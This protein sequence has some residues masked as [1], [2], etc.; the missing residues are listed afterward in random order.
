[1]RNVID[2]RDLNRLIDEELFDRDLRM[3]RAASTSRVLRAARA[4]QDSARRHEGELANG[5]GAAV[6]V[7]G[8]GVIFF[9]LVTAWV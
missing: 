9:V 6:L 2:H 5:A 3:A 1:M 7:T 4:V 8:V